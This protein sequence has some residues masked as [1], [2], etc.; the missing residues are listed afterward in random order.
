MKLLIRDYVGS[1]RER[2]E[3]DVILPDLLSETGYQVF[4]RP[5]IGTVQRGVDVAAVG[6]DKDGNRTVYLFC[7]KP[8][9]LTRPEWDGPPQ[10]MRPSLNQILDEYI[11][12]WLPP[13]YRGL[14]VVVVLCLGGD[15][16]EGIRSQVSSYTAQNTKEGKITFEEWNGDKIAEM[17]LAGLLREKVLPKPLQSHFQKA[18]AM[19]DQPEIAYEHFARLIHALRAGVKT[20]KD[21]VRVA[22]QINICLWVL[23]VWA[24]DI[25]NLDAPYRASEL[26][27]LNVW[28]LLRPFFPKRP[29][30]KSTIIAVW[31]ELIRLHITIS[32]HYLDKKV[33]PYTGKRHAL[34]RAIRSAEA[35]DIN[36]KLFDV[37]GRLALTG[38]W[39]T[40]IATFNGA[41]PSADVKDTLKN[42]VKSGI[43]LIVNNPALHLPISDDQAIDVA[44]FLCLAGYLRLGLGDIEIWL[45]EMAR[46]LRV[47]VYQHGRYPCI[48]REYRD[49]LDHPRHQTDEYRKE[50][51]AGSTLVP[52]IAAWLAAFGN[53]DALKRLKELK[54][55]P[56]S[57]CTLQLWVPEAASEDH[58]YLDDATHGV[59]VPDLPLTEDG[60]ALL[61]RIRDAC[62]NSD[63]FLKL[64]AVR[65]R[66]LPVVLTACRHYRLPVP[67]QLWI[68]LLLPRK[69]VPEG[70]GS[71]PGANTAPSNTE[72]NDG[73]R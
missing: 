1:L 44:L 66:H 61:K 22:R 43:E 13:A 36:L 69:T 46:R 70:D 60:Q 6:H 38:H 4:S 37:L 72:P 18:V 41:G 68:D 59:A 19:V 15:V 64:S 34:S 51:T 65:S 11:P 7:V 50:A 23:F 26:A 49:L 71:N 8:G 30:A 52:L 5:S 27:L 33:I 54:E 62:D 63:G 17:I 28:D 45:S 3:L 14:P 73:E 10:T 32:S 16:H 42:A 20:D 39:I 35:V 57:H 9:D 31:Y 25:D 67:P 21:R 55:G 2:N 47:T 12:N 29:Q 24:R 48:F 40:W 56:L 58:L 53:R